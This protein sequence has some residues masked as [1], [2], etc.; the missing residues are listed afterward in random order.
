VKFPGPTRQKRRLRR[1]RHLP[2]LPPTA[3]VTTSMARPRVG[4]DGRP[5]GGHCVARRRL[6]IPS[7][8]YD[9]LMARLDR[10]QP[11]KQVAQTAA[12]IGRDFDYRLLRAILPLD[13][14]ALQDAL[15]RLSA[16]EL[17]FKRGTPP[18]AKYVF[19]HA[20]VRDAAYENLLKTRRQSVH[21]KL[22][23]VL[24]QEGAAPEILAQHAVA[25]G[26]NDL[27]IRSWLAAGES[28]AS[29]FAN[30]EAASHFKAAIRLLESTPEVSDRDAFEFGAP[31]RP[32]V[33]LDGEVGV[34]VR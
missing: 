1:A 19:K 9:S 15:D 22:V 17:I 21:A 6:T 5:K 34:R 3:D 2:G 31:Q 23:A 16:A 7:T 18:D 8:L 13:D 30:Q 24:K 28:A 4:P 12:C 26:D 27:A 14:I 32:H 20:L 11:V 29:R 10:L 33:C 25:A